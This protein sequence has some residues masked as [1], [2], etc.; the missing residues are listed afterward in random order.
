M[1]VL[2]GFVAGTAFGLFAV[3]TMLPMDFPDKKQAFLA[4][5]F[6]RFA[7]GFV[8]LNMILPA[9][10]RLT[11]AGIGLLL[12]LSDAIITRAYAPILIMGAAGG[13]VI[14]LAAQWLT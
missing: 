10:V 7:I 11:G 12:S 14:A 8:V 13:A 2:T 3:L 1:N 6:S 4:A 9:P 5:F